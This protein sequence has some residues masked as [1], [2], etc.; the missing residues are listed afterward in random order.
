MHKIVF[1][2]KIEPYLKLLK[3]NGREIARRLGMDY[4]RYNY[5]LRGTVKE[6]KEYISIIEEAKKFH[7]EYSEQVSI[8]AA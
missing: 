5:F 4:Q 6:A 1:L 7:K 2:K 8:P 3:G